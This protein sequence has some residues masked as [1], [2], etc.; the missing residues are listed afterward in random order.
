LLIT[1]FLGVQTAATFEQ[2]ELK[3]VWPYFSGPNLNNC[4]PPSVSQG[5]LKFLKSEP[6][7]SKFLYVR[8]VNAYSLLVR[9]ILIELR[10]EIRTARLLGVK[11]LP[12]HDIQARKQF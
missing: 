10:I 3:R 6:I 9:P 12:L 5:C 2:L 8:I 7:L 1:C 4:Q 11:Y